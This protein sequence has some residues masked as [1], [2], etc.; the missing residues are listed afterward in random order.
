MNKK[1]PDVET[2]LMPETEKL[3]DRI[4]SY[5]D[6]NNEDGLRRL[7]AKSNFADIAD[8]FERVFQPEQRLRC[9]PLLETPLAAQ[10]LTSLEHI[11]QLE[12]LSSISPQLSSQVLRLMASDDA[13]DL[14]Q[15]LQL[16][17]ARKILDAMPF[18]PETR[19][20]HH[21]MREEPDSAAGLMSTNFIAMP[22]ESTVAGALEQIRHAQEKDFLYY[23]Y[24]IDS[25]EELVGV[26]SL[27]KLILAL[28]EVPLNQLASFDIKSVLLTFDQEL[29]ANLFRKYY[30]LL[31][32]PVVD[33]QNHL[34][35]IVTLD[36]VVDII[37]EESSQDIYLASGINI[38]QVDE[39]NLL[40]G[41]VFKAVRARLPW[42]M[43]T[44]VGQ[45]FA[46]SII[47]SYREVMTLAVISVS[48][49][50]LLS[51]LSGNMGAQ[52]ETISVRGLA[53]NMIDDS[54]IM[55]KI[56]RE[57]KIGLITGLFFGATVGLYALI[58]FHHGLLALFLFFSIVSALCLS[59]FLGMVLPYSFQKFLKQ[60]PAGVGG[61][62]ITTLLDI[63][64]FSL[65]LFVLKHFLN[66][67]F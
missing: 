21:L 67:M 59:S 6:K 11:H 61:P 42:L 51:G 22:V 53:M 28:P 52:S 23:I 33:S 63:L 4:Q 16:E 47:A 20:L 15:E 43:V 58:V 56:K 30:N 65:Y 41:S 14:L 36:D 27:K 35:G 57:F 34:R 17:D 8:V 31:A 45:L 5:L 40:T 64:T 50:P 46:S 3:A 9:F 12:C 37:D 13:V 1:F 44:M 62:L 10:V 32:M 55:D 38:E 60:D 39:K 49:M 2:R 29:V 19:S 25:N 18:D 48:F 7:L 26:V 24:L 66:Q 54:N